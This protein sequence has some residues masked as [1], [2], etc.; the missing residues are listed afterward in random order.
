MGVEPTSWWRA[1]HRSGPVSVGSFSLRAPLVRHGACAV[2]MR[3]TP[4]IPP[5]T[6]VSLVRPLRCGNIGAQGPP[7]GVPTSF[8]RSDCPRGTATDCWI[9]SIAVHSGSMHSACGPERSLPA[10]KAFWCGSTASLSCSAMGSR[11]PG[12]ARRYRRGN[13]CIRSRSQT[14]SPL[15]F[16]AIPARLSP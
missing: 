3:P 5:C 7:G 8:V 9:A 12:A 10:A 14:P 13:D 16:L 2:G 6:H 1:D 11:Y 15:T 4:G